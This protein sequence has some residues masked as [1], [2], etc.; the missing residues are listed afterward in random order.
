MSPHEQGNTLQTWSRSWT[1]TYASSFTNGGI[2]S[3]C[4]IYPS[5]LSK[6]ITRLSIPP[7]DFSR[8][9]KKLVTFVWVNKQKSETYT[10][11][12]WV[13]RNKV[14]STLKQVRLVAGY[15]YATSWF[16]RWNVNTDMM[17]RADWYHHTDTMIMRWISSQIDARINI[18][19]RK[20]LRIQ[21][22]Q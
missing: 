4:L 20:T 14:S 22:R 13:T 1:P 8:C 3:S 16:S 10:A 5:P 18:K 2:G 6:L 17:T 21:L 7:S 15:H 19:H 11:G 9:F 12:M